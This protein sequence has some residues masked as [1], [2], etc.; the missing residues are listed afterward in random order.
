VIASR[1]VELEVRLFSNTF[2]TSSCS[3]TDS[4]LLGSGWVELVYIVAF[5]GTLDSSNWPFA[6]LGWM[7]VF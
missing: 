6:F 4:F 7:T 2:T 1:G 5:L 3:F